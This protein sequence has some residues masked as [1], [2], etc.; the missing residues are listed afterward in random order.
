MAQHPLAG[1][2]APHDML[3]NVP[4]LISAYYTREPDPSNPA[5]QRRLRHLGPPRL[6]PAAAAST[7]RTSSPSRRPSASTARRRASPARCSSAWTR[8]RSPSRRSH[9]PSR[10]SPRNGQ[11]IMIAAATPRRRRATLHPHAGHLARD[12]RRTTAAATSGLADGVVITPSHNPPDDGGF[13]YNPPSGGPA[14]TVTTKAMQ[15]RAN[16]IMRE[17]PGRGAGACRSPGRSRPRRPTCTI[18]SPRTSRTSSTSSTSRPS[19]A[20][21]LRIGV[22]PMGGASVAYWQPIAEL[23]G[24][25]LEVVNPARRP[26][27][28]LHDRGQ[29]R[30][31]PHGLLVALRDGEP[32]RAQGPL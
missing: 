12:P 5:E 11:E 10:C 9:P 1:K 15:A 23:Y 3:V 17:R 32:G 21:G 19:Q 7:R 2:P 25:N 13:K 14:D 28:R 22:D 20:S 4:R 29:G 8:T 6:V 30:Q 16:E 27:L 18:T 31:D 24:L 26:D